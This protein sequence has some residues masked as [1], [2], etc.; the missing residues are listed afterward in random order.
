MSTC[1]HLRAQRSLREERSRK[2][3]FCFKLMQELAEKRRHHRINQI[4]LAFVDAFQVRTQLT[5][6]ETKKDETRWRK[7]NRKPFVMTWWL[8]KQLVNFAVRRQDDPRQP[9]GRPEAFEQPPRSPQPF[10]TRDQVEQ[11]L[12]ATSPRYRALFHFLADTGTRIGE[13][14][15]SPGT[16]WTW[17]TKWCTSGRRRA[18]SPRR[19]TSESYS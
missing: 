15:G 8:I 5:A 4:D 11:I 6:S 19:A 3:L 13:A 16:M 12:K 10:W 14:A 17:T 7:P 9:A 2:Y 18:G 1:A